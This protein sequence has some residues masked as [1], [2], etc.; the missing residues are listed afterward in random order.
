[1][2]LFG[3]TTAPSSAVTVTDAGF[4]LTN[5]VTNDNLYFTMAP[6]FMELYNN[7]LFLAGFSSQLSTVYWS[8]IGEPEG[9]DPTFNAEF[10]TNDG[11]RITSLKTYNGSLVVTKERSIHRVTGDNPSNFSLQEISDQ[12]GCISNRAIVVWENRCWFLDTKG[13]C[14]YDSASIRIVSNKIEDLFKR[15]NLSAARDNAAA[16]H[17]RDQNE[18]W[19][20]FPID[21]ANYNNCIAVYDYLADA[22]TRYEGVQVSSLWLAQGTLGRK[23]VI[24]GGYTGTVSF[25]G[26]TFTSDL[27]QAITCTIKTPFFFE[28]GQTIEKQWRRFYLNVDPVIGITQPISVNF[29]TDYGTAASLSRTMYQA[30][31]Q[32][33]IDF[34]LVARSVQAEIVHSSETLSLRVYG[35]TF[36]SRFQ[37]NV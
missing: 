31:F 30:P 17:N 18:V 34:G 19:F 16:I 27:G 32:S 5:L 20:T 9:I 25:F 15:M 26:S 8:N 22:W 13:I 2:D 11:D 28:Q 29:Y 7:Q 3:T 1:M 37:R 24:V 36:E 35:Y 6:R 33:R 4:P 14:E 10:R 23:S 12:Y 21:G